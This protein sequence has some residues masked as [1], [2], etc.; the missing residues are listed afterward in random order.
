MNIPAGQLCELHMMAKPYIKAIQVKKH[1]LLTG[2]EHSLKIIDKQRSC[3][4]GI[5]ANLTL[6]NGKH[7]LSQDLT[8]PLILHLSFSLK[9]FD[10]PSL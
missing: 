3:K 2:T 5:K 6:S 10:F 1:V 7:F 4:E 8:T 9:A